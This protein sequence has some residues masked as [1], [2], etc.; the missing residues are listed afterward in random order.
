MPSLVNGNGLEGPVN[1]NGLGAP[2]APSKVQ[3]AAPV[4]TVAP[5]LT[6]LATSLHLEYPEYPIDALVERIEANTGALEHALTAHGF[7]AADKARSLAKLVFGAGC[8]DPG[9]PTYHE[10]KELN[11]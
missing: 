11:W 7:T 8:V 1:G 9:S 10:E 3:A 5:T 2:V 4:H 6:S